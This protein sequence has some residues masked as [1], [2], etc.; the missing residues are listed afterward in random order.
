MNERKNK[1]EKIIEKEKITDVAE[2]KLSEKKMIVVVES[3]TIETKDKHVL[4]STGKENYNT[5]I[6]FL[7]P[8]FTENERE[9]IYPIYL[10]VKNNH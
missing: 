10:P 8:G 1:I 4:H 2:Y 6:F 5:D 7:N 9:W 3:K